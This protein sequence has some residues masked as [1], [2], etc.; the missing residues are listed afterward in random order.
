MSLPQR[1]AV[2]VLVRQPGSTDE[3]RDDEVV[4]GTQA[5]AGAAPAYYLERRERQSNRQTEDLLVRRTLL[6]ERDVP[7]VD[8]QT[9]MELEFT[10]DGEPGT[11]AG[12]VKNVER[13]RY[14]PAGPVQTTR[15]TLEDA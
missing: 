7:P 13:R 10:V 11:Q 15:L 8:W 9:E 5:F 3:W 12:T 6:L 14:S 2:L 1:N 4:E